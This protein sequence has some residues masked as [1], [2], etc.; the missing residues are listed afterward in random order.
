MNGNDKRG[1]NLEDL[2][3][4]NFIADDVGI[5]FNSAAAVGSRYGKADRDEKRVLDVIAFQTF[6]DAYTNLQSEHPRL[7]NI[8][9]SNFVK[10]YN[11]SQEYESAL[12]LPKVDKKG[13]AYVWHEY[14]GQDLGTMRVAALEGYKLKIEEEADDVTDQQSKQGTPSAGYV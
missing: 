2:I 7:K 13:P 11:P 4:N 1:E 8:E 14:F 9:F 5:V 6:S 10:L 12:R 3:I